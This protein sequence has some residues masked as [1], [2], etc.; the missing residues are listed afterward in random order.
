MPLLTPIFD[1]EF[2]AQTAALAEVRA[3]LDAACRDAGM[4]ERATGDLV[5]AVNEACMNVIQ[6][7]YAYAPDAVF[8]L[9]LLQDGGMLHVHVLDN[10]RPAGLDDL[11]PRALDDLRPGGLGVHFMR[12]LSDGIDYLPAPAGYGNLL[13]IS[14]RIA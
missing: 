9:R 3:A 14:K 12:Q 2:P 6:H 8:R 10:A 4:G 13:Q 11:C 7:G 1:Q 5:L